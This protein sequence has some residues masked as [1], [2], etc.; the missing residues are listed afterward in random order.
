[1]FVALLVFVLQDNHNCVEFEILYGCGYEDFY[2]LGY[3]TMS[4]RESLSA[5]RRNIPA[6]SSEP[7]SRPNKKEYDA[8]ESK[9]VLVCS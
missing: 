6:P 3:N 4:P 1:M 7:K 2:L 5:F 9:V 8:D